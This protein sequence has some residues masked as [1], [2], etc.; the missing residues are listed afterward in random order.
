[1]GAIGA[2]LITLG[3]LPVAAMLVLWERI[4]LGKLTQRPGPNRVGPRGLLQTIADALKLLTKEDF[5]PKDADRILFFL[6]PLI[7]I[8]PSFLVFA[9]VPFGHFGGTHGPVLIADLRT[10]IFFMV[11]VFS[12]HT[13][14]ILMAGWA[15]NNKYSLLGGIRGVA[16]AISYELPLIFSFLGILILSGSMSTVDII[17]AQGGGLHNWFFLAQPVAFLVY[18]ACSV[19]EVNR[20]PFDIPEAESELVSGFNTE[21]SGMRF[22]MFFLA[23]YVSLFATAAIATIVF[24]GG[25]LAPFPEPAVI[26]GSTLG[27]FFWSAGWFL[28]KVF[29]LVTLAMWVRGTLPR[30]RA[31]QLM[32]FAWKFLVPVVLVNLFVTGLLALWG[33]WAVAGGLWLALLLWALYGQ[34][35]AAKAERRQVVY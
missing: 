4:F 13:V 21:Y 29:T 16:Q 7:F 30:L 27:Y 35:R 25:W 12:L 8:V 19:A 26:T 15:S 22:A 14:G 2:L 24:L 10:G 18:L 9:V 11:A 1:M 31:D 20:V 3:M 33:R 28:L 34:S 23:E 17:K 32:D 5:T 6:A